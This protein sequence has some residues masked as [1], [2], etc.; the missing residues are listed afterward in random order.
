MQANVFDIYQIKSTQGTLVFESKI[1]NTTV[2]NIPNGSGGAM[3]IIVVDR[4]EFTAPIK[5]GTINTKR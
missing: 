5:L 4:T 3:Q 2:N 1:A